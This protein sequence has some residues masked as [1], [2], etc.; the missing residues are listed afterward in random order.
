MKITVTGRKLHITDGIRDHLN[1]KM[2]KTISDIN[3]ETDIHVCLSLEKHHQFA[4]FAVKK[5]D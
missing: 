3:D 1:K 2:N 4:A 5:R